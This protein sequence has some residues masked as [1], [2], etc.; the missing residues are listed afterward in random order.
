MKFI[1]ETLRCDA[2]DPDPVALCAQLTPGHWL[3]EDGYQPPS[4]HAPGLLQLG[5]ALVN[6]LAFSLSSGTLINLTLGPAL[7]DRLAQ[8]DLLF[9]PLAGLALHELMTNAVIHG[10]LQVA[11]GVS[12]DWN[13]VAQREFAIAE[14]LTHV[15]RAARMT[16]VAVGWCACEVVFVVADEGNG[17]DHEAAPSTSRSSGRGLRL[18]RLVGQVNVLCGGRKTTMVIDCSTSLQAATHNA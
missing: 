16:T 11:S 13:D 6:G 14:L 18:A 10:N 9:S 7:I 15:S 1:R 17:Y 4:C 2:S 5:H 3:I 12:G 8:L